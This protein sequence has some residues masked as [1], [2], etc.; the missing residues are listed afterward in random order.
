MNCYDILIKIAQKQ[1]ERIHID[2]CNKTIKVGRQIIVE[3]GQVRQNKIIVGSDSYEFDGLIENELDINELYAQYKVSLPSERD[4]GRHYFKALSVNELTDTQ[5]VT[6]LPRL[7]ARIRLESYILLASASRILK[8]E[9]DS[10]WFWQGNDKDF[11][12]LK[13]Y[14]V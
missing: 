10:K 5:M 1:Y 4:R 14:V 8:W 13:R 9:D 7:E 11:I 3:N 6:S 12:I 2:L